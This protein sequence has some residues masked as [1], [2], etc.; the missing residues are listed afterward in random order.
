MLTYTKLHSPLSVDISAGTNFGSD[1]NGYSSF[2][3]AYT[4]TKWLEF[5][6]LCMN[7]VAFEVIPQE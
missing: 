3:Y 5:I 6:E 7:V 4:V 1:A 2:F